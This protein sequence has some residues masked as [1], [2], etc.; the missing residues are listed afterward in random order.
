MDEALFKELLESVKQMDEIAQGKRE[1]SQEY[2]FDEL[3]IHSFQKQDGP[4][5]FPT[6]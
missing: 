6:E 1:P 2:H 5:R 3:V 4:R